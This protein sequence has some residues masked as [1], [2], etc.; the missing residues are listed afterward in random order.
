M[1]TKAHYAAW[2]IAALSGGALACESK[3]AEAAPPRPLPDDVRHFRHNGNDCYL[4]ERRI[5]GHLAVALACVRA[6]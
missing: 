2:I 1:I 3:A 5:V 6:P 4:Y